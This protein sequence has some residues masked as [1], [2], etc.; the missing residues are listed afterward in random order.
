MQWF[1]IVKQYR[2]QQFLDLHYTHYIKLSDIVGETIINFSN[3]YWNMCFPRKKGGLRNQ[4]VE[5]N[6]VFF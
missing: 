4:N 5:S 3:Q 1:H 2:I 6:I